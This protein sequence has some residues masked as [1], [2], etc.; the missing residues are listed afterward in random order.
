[1]HKLAQNFTQRIR[2]NSTTDGFMYLSISANRSRYL[3]DFRLET[4]SKSGSG[5]ICV[6]SALGRSRR[7]SPSSLLG[8]LGETPDRRMICCRKFDSASRLRL[9][10]LG[11]WTRRLVSVVVRCPKPMC[12]GWYR[13]QSTPL[14]SLLLRCL[15]LVEKKSGSFRVTRAR[16]RTQTLPSWRTD[17]V[18]CW[19]E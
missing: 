7:G 13:V 10:V 12:T 2:A 15:L 8:E 1:M 17:L 19:C 18:R 4:S 9:M 14:V 3:C 5:H 16:R 6:G 11:W